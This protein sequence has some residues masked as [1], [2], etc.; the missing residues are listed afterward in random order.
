LDRALKAEHRVLHARINSQSNSHSQ[1]IARILRPL[2]YVRRFLLNPRIRWENLTRLFYLGSHLQGA[3]YSEQNRY[4]ELFA[5]CAARLQRA[6]SPTI[7]SF[8]CATG[9]EA[10]S[11]AEYLPNATIIGVD[12]NHWCLRQGRNANRSPRVHF[13]HTRSPDFAALANLDAIFAMAVFQRSQNR[14]HTSAV[15]HRGFPFASFEQQ[16]AHLDAKLKP[17]GIFFI[18]HADFRFEDTVTA[19]NYTPLEFEGSSF[20][21]HRP[22]FG[23]RNRL[24]T[25]HYVMHR[26]FQ[27]RPSSPS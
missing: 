1:S 5:E 20:D 26:A 17:G 9:E 16:I 24:I 25:T 19:A 8:G 15:A 13:L 23:P 21:H 22:I 6:P 27:K 10:F 4:P 11:L 14:N 7:L 18:D 3:T 2:G 12:I